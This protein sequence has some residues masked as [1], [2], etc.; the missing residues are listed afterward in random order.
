[1]AYKGDKLVSGFYQFLEE[2]LSAINYSQ[3]LA[4]GIEVLKEWLF[5]IYF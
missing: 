4:C 2:F 3:H 5:T 1:M